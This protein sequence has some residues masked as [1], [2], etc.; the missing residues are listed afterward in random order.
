[1]LGHEVAE[2]T[3]AEYMK[4]WRP[5]K[6]PSQTWKTFLKNHGSALAAMDFFVVPTV[7]F[8]LL[9]VLVILS[10]DRRRVV[11]VNVTSAPSARWVAQQL[12]E[13]FPFERV[14]RY[15]IHDRNSI[16]GE[17]VHRCLARLNVEEVVTA[18]RSP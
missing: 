16:F 2:A 12:R 18:P 15:L 1:M 7:T 8:R 5:D 3:V 17:A 6:P 4:R 11:H 10:H 13:A 14:P 9:Y